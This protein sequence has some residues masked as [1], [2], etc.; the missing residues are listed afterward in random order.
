MNERFEIFTVLIAKINR[1]IYKIKAEEMAEFEL[2]SSHVSCL[3]YLYKAGSLTSRELCD[4]CGE[5]K[6]NISRAIKYLEHQGFLHCESNGSKR[7][8]SH[9]SLTEQGRSVGE[10]IAKKVDRILLAAGEELSEEH[11]LIMYE[12]LQLIYR[13]LQRICD[14]YCEND[15]D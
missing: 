12:S 9:L 13:N 1:C 14:K 3:Y 6:A 15:P 8:Q 10:M 11:R 2:K 5:D 4:V 7:Y